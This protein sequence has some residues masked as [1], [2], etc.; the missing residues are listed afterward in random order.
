MRSAVVVGIG[1]LGSVFARGLL[2]VGCAVIPV[3]RGT[4]MAEVAREAPAPELALVAVAEGD[5]DGVLRE[6]PA[7]WRGRVG[8]LQNELRPSAWEA[9]R[10][11]AP[12][13]AVVWF[14]KKPTTLVKELLPSVLHGP[15][16]ALLAEALG[17]LG[18]GA[19]V[20]ESEPELRFALARKNLYILTTNIAGMVTGGTV[21]AL[22]RDQRE[23]ALGVAREVLAAE[24]RLMGADLDEALL[25]EGLEAAVDADPDHACTGR[26]APARLG[27]LLAHAGRLGVEV[28]TLARIAEERR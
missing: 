10:L 17:A 3:T 16:S 6:L 2:R 4:P 18:L 11:E 28:P 25:L 23:L 15:A 20:V 7:A 13:V 22:F 8:L 24:R 27:R 26:S 19:R 21:G 14:E 12:T 5:L 9:H 1:E